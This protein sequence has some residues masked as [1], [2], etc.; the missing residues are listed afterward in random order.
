[1]AERVLGQV[2]VEM[3]LKNQKFMTSIRNTT[4]ALRQVKS[5]MRANASQIAFYGSAFTN[6]A[7]KE[8][9]FRVKQQGLI[10]ELQAQENQMKVL[11]R[12]FNNSITKQG[13][14]SLATGKYA[15]Q[16]NNLT[17][18]MY[19][20][21][22]AYVENAKGMAKMRAET[23]GLSGTIN[24]VGKAS[25]SAG[26]SLRSIGSTMTQNV[27]VPIAAGFAYA[28]KKVVDFDNT[29]NENKN[30]I[31]VTNEFEFFLISSGVIL[32]IEICKQ[33]S[34]IS[35][36][37]QHNILISEKRQRLP[38]AALYSSSVDKMNRILKRMQDTDI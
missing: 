33:Q 18:R 4:A 26:S 15:T 27:T 20:L 32:N 23:M 35:F 13:E 17:S 38:L 1:M 7:M 36:S 16:I 31:R 14:W 2:A 3:D 10:R 6:A 28:I 19:D 5:E 30:L 22:T 29:M 37:C 12:Q 24:K 21:K 8:E 25:I 11:Q 34:Q 9:A